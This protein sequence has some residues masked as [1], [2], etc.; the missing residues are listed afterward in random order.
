MNPQTDP[1]EQI[2]SPYETDLGGFSVRRALPS[3]QCPMVGP[4]IFFDHMGPARFPVGE[5]VAV[6][7]HPHIGIAT[8]TWLF[9][10]EIIHRDSLGITQAIRPGAVNLMTAGRGIVHSERSTPEQRE[11]GPALHGIQLWLALPVELEEMEPAFHHTSAAN[12]PKTRQGGAEIAV[13]IGAAYGLASPVTVYSPTLYAGVTFSE[14]GGSVELPENYRERAVYVVEGAVTVGDTQVGAGTMAVF[15]EGAAASLVAKG[16]A[17]VMIIGGEPFP[18]ERHIWWNYVSSS[19]ES[20]EQ[21]KE[22]WIERRFDPV[23]DD[24]EFIPLP[25]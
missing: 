11:T 4:Y 14:A 19:P 23:P 25:E 3:A 2:L 7:P 13:I 9:E 22:D 21:A 1:I 8:V 15:R 24:P 20:I 12:I 5:G 16:L 10:G 18:E 6:C 17:K